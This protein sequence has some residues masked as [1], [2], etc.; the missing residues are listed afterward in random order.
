MLLF[1]HR[2]CHAQAPENS[3]AAFQ[4]AVEMGVDGI[5]TDV[6]LSADGL[7][8]I[9]HDRLTPQQR[10]VAELTRREI[11]HDV[12]H[13]VPVLDEILDAFPDVIWNI[14]IKNPEAAQVAVGTLTYFQP[15]RRLLV[16]SFRHDVVRQCA[17]ELGI[18]AAL[19]LASRPLDVEAL[20]ADCAPT[21]TIKAIV[22]DYNVVDDKV[23][24]VVAAKGWRNY[25]YGA[26]TEREHAR[27][28]Q[29]GIA[30]LITDYPERVKEPRP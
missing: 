27:C 19:L 1:A 2:G 4:A 28:V 17:A 21:P 7:A 18:D 29:S 22:W 11:E 16:S 24:D 14:E 13:A 26:I 3:F 20:I 6:R 12:G 5:E 9:I 25:I 10:P 30:G 23:L 15:K 8:V